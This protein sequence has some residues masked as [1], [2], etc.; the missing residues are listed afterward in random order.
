M[1]K[2]I[3]ILFVMLLVAATTFAQT[4]KGQFIVSGKSSLDFTYSNTKLE[5]GYLPD[6]VSQ[7]KYDLT[8]SPAIGYFVIDNLAVVLQTS[9]GIS[10]GKLEDQTSQL[11]LI[12][13]AIYYFPASEIVRPFVQAGAGYVNISNKTSL[14]TG[15]KATQSFNGYTL[16][17][18]V[19]VAFF[20]KENIAIELVGQYA[21]INTSYS[22]DSSLKL[23]MNGISGAI[24]FSLFF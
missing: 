15:G 14:D 10:D 19:G 16:A 1:K 2:R 4:E 9:Y 12:P 5:A 11:S 20:V 21:T 7:E 13:S 8:I 17:G 6:E 23:N 18:G 3:Y 22:G 24:G